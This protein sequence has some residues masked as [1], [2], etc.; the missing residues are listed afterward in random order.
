LADTT[1]EK[2]QGGVRI[3]WLFKREDQ[4]HAAY[5]GA[6]ISDRAEAIKKKALQ[7][8][9]AAEVATDPTACSDYLNLAR[10]LRTKLEAT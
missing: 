10:Q 3:G 9:R 1:S 2:Y 7:Y 5:L 6:N 4:M 8:E